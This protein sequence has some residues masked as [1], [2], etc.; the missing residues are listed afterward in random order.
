MAAKVAKHR[1]LKGI[2][3]ELFIGALS[4]LSIAQSHSAVGG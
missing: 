3:Y 4:I 1:E 2:G